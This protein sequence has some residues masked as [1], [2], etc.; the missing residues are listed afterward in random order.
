M[1]AKNIYRI[2]NS[3]LVLLILEL[4]FWGG[5]ASFHFGVAEKMEGFRYGYPHALWGLYFLPLIPLA[6]ITHL[7]W[8]ERALSRFGDQDL[9]LPHLKEHM[10]RKSLIRNGLF[11][12]GLGL[13]LLALA[14]P[15]VGTKK[16]EGKTK[17]FDLMVC[18][19]LSNSMKAEDIRPSRLEK[20][21]RALEKLLDKLHGDRIGMVVFAGEPYVQLP[22]TS[23][24]SAARI[25]L[26]NI[27]T[28]IVPVQGTSVGAAIDLARR[29]FDKKA[30]TKKAIIVI[31]DGENHQD[32][33]VKAAKRAAE[34]GI[35]VHTVGMGTPEGGPIPLYK[36]RRQVGYKKDGNGN[37]V[38]S[39]LNAKVLSRTAKAGKGTFV[40]ANNTRVGLNLLMDELETMKRKTFQT[41]V[42]TD[43][44]N[45][46]QLFLLPGTFLLFFSVLLGVLPV[47]PF[48]RKDDD[49]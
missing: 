48:V 16:E 45:R 21:K 8:K 42:Y 13:L 11:R 22:I 47:D 7:L 26:S 5:Y 46:F 44:A 33:P 37:T 41:T 36:N 20:A 23:D 6:F 32:D 15:Q 39:K 30:A 14:D 35:V 31:S 24:L 28:D 38:I 27:S 10:P 18:L 29:S 1:T 34:K 17:G 3:A 12:F 4:L 43:H 19:D 2:R 9:I 49:R 25:F 40:R